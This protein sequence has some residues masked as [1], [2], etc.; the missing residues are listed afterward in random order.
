MISAD[1]HFLVYGMAFVYGLMFGSFFNVC[2]YRIPKGLSLVSPRS[3][4]PKCGFMIPWFL[5]VPVLSYVFLRGKCA[6]CRNPISRVYPVVELL[7]GL[8]AFGVFWH[9]RSLHLMDWM[10]RS[11]IDFVF[12]ASLLISSFIDLRYLIIPDRFTIGGT[13]FGILASTAYPALHGF[14]KWQE[15]LIYSSMS[16]SFATPF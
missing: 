10:I 6:G 12:L 9:F 3:S 14:E 4:C 16:L 5:N 8:L 13:F 15:G 2:I 11:A 1:F 7:T